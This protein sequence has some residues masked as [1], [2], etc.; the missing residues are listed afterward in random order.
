MVAH[1]TAKTVRSLISNP[2][3]TLKTDNRRNVIYQIKCENSDKYCIGS[4]L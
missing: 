3:E 4:N 2:K 1:E